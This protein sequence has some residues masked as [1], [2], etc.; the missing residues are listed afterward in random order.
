MCEEVVNNYLTKYVFECVGTFFPIVLGSLACL[1]CSTNFN[2]CPDVG[3]GT[4]IVFPFPL[5]IRAK[6]EIIFTRTDD[7][8]SSVGT[9][10]TYL[11]STLYCISIVL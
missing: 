7:A 1:G 3:P 2:E 8:S 9:R 11:N 5:F 6:R 10:K 4:V